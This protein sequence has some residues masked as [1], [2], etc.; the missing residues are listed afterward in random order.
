MRIVKYCVL[1]D[2]A[3]AVLLASLVFFS[4]FFPCY[5]LW[6]FA[7]VSILLVSGLAV[8]FASVGVVA[9]RKWAEHI[10][11]EREQVRLSVTRPCPLCSNLQVTAKCRL[12]RKVCCSIHCLSKCSKYGCKKRYCIDH[13]HNLAKCASC[14]IGY[15]SVH[16]NRC[17]ACG[18]PYCMNHIT[19]CTYCYNWCCNAA[20][21]YHP[22]PY[23]AQL[24]YV[25]EGQKRVSEDLLCSICAQPLLDPFQHNHTGS[26]I[27]SQLSCKQ[28]IL[29]Q[30][31]SQCN[32]CHNN[33]KWKQIRISSVTKMFLFKPLDEVYVLCPNCNKQVMRGELWEHICREHLGTPTIDL[34]SG[35]LKGKKRNN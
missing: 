24:V 15:C 10:R 9:Y 35:Q 30:N 33:V 25:N 11:W 28:C 31:K 19:K 7:G 27:C 32:H 17:N 14:N 6:R 5:G 13:E 34:E 26:S 3:A 4:F 23:F 21:D 2:P 1:E 22:C 20:L 8:A 16:I 29:K 12:C 18:N